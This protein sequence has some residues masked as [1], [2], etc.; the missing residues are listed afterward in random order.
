MYFFVKKHH[1]KENVKTTSL[2]A[3]VANLWV[4][5]RIHRRSV[6]SLQHEAH[7]GMH[8]TDIFYFITIK[9][10]LFHFL[11]FSWPPD[12]WL[13]PLGTRLVGL[14]GV[15]V[16]S[17][18]CCHLQA[19]HCVIWHAYFCWMMDIWFSIS[20]FRFIKLH[21]GLLLRQWSDALSIGL[22]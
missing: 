22:L 4:L 19:T 8:G 2:F 17:C 7:E 16:I 12:P 10:S 18:K 11:G 21:V 20:T 15:F 14:T 13:T 9:L 1:I 6:D 5:G 3:V